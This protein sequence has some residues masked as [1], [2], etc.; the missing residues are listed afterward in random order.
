MKNKI[1]VVD[2]DKWFREYLEKIISAEGHEVESASNAYEAIDK[3][4]KILPDVIVLDILLPG[5]NGVALLNELS[6][7]S[8]TRVVPVIICSAVSESIP[9]K[10]LERYGI[11]KVLDKATMDPG[12]LL[13]SIRSLLK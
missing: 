10:N 9:K 12:D 2:D 4:D 13:V 5:S 3:I 11:K 1:L 7:Y 6:S 8:D